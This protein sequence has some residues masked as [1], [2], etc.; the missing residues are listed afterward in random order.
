MSDASGKSADAKVTNGASTAPATEDSDIRAGMAAARDAESLRKQADETPKASAAKGPRKST[1]KP[2]RQSASKPAGKSAASR[3]AK[4]APP[5]RANAAPPK[6]EP[7]T[8]L[9]SLAAFSAWTASEGE[10][11]VSSQMARV[12]ALVDDM[13]ARQRA[14]LESLAEARLERA[15]GAGDLSLQYLDYLA[16]NT[17][18]AYEALKEMASAADAPAAL[19][20]QSRFLRD[21]A[22]TYGEQAQALQGAML[23]YLQASTRPAEGLWSGFLP[24]QAKA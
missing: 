15:R 19:D 23:A 11:T 6:S 12:R 2:A 1:S 22:K 8:P 14:T 16:A 5:K 10:E 24:R 13:T 3:R 20:V 21:S 17:A 9:P 4:T 18:T 7:V